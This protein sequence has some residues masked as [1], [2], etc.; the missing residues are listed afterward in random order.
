LPGCPSLPD[1]QSVR[2]PHQPA[3]LPNMAIC[4]TSVILSWPQGFPDQTLGSIDCVDFYM[5]FIVSHGV[6]W[7][8]G[9]PLGNVLRCSIISHGIRSPA[10]TLGDSDCAGCY[11]IFHD[12][13]CYPEAFPDP[14]GRQFGWFSTVLHSVPCLSWGLGLS[15]FLWDTP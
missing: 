6:P 13:P 15:S 11:R 1:S 2:L 3:S 14:W 9:R 12:I 7:H 10:R 8:W 5:I 4:D